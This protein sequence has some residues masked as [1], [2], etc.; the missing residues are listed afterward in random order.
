M[1]RSSQRQKDVRR[2]AGRVAVAEAEVDVLPQCLRSIGLRGVILPKLADACILAEVA[3][4]AA[5][6]A[7]CSSAGGRDRLVVV[8][9][10]PGSAIFGAG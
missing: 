8:A 2:V 3:N 7:E 10:W 6:Q 9:L 1:R 4:V 5:R